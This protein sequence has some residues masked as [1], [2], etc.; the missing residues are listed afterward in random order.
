MYF[1]TILYKSFVYN[2]SMQRI[3]KLELWDIKR[4]E[5]DIRILGS[6]HFLTNYANSA[7]MQKEINLHFV[8][9]KL[10]FYSVSLPA[11]IV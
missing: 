2:F 3:I 7:I 6:L 5:L 1:K 8:N 10:A 4:I 11:E 9:N